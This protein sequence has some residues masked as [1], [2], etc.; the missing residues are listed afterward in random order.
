[1]KSKTGKEVDM[2]QLR[3]FRKKYYARIRY[4]KN[5]HQTEKLVPLRTSLKVEAIERLTKVNRSENDI[6]E[7]IKYSF[8]WMNPQ[9]QLK[10]MRFTLKNTIPLYLNYQKGNGCRPQSVERT[11]Y[12]LKNLVKTLGKE[13]FIENIQTEEIEQFKAHLKGKLT[14]VGVNI[15]LTRIKGFLNW[16]KDIKRIISVVPVIKLIRTPQKLPAYLTEENQS[17]ILMLDWLDD[18][19]KSVFQFYWE[20]GCRL[21]EPFHG[22]ISGSWLIVTPERSKTGL[23]REIHLSRNQVSIVYTLQKKQTESKAKFK[24][25]TNNYSRIFKKACISI[26]REDL[27]FHNLRDTFAVIRYLTTRDIYQVSKELGHT[28]VKVTE[29]YAQFRMKRLEQ[30]FP[31]LAL[32]YINRDGKEGFGIQ[33]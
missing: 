17:E 26:S 15:N 25:F 22:S 29:K 23:Q 12:C 32:G 4:R 3:K 13:F 28:T 19:Y 6:I 9:R 5:N 2:A 14:E 21:R 33:N 18:H 27:H 7:G 24:S 30:D 31:T 16:C 11:H 20:T 8:P 10:I 1:V